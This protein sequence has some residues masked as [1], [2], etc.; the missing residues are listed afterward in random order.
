M[1]ATENFFSDYTYT[2]KDS[3]R[4][5]SYTHL[6]TRFEYAIHL[7]ILSEPTALLLCKSKACR[8]ENTGTHWARRQKIKGI[9][10][11]EAMFSKKDLSMEIFCEL[12]WLFIKNVYESTH[13]KR[14]FIPIHFSEKGW[15]VCKNLIW[16]LKIIA[17]QK[18]SK[19]LT[20]CLH[21]ILSI[22]NLN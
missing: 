9:S 21:W 1:Y 4:L 16:S 7:L 13:T 17:S 3:Q 10:F 8:R 22:V 6:P 19:L 12:P 14:K 15:S 20:Q 11:T 2:L 5:H 18:I